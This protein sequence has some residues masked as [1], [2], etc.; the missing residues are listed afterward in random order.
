MSSS[1]RSILSKG[2]KKLL[3]DELFAPALSA[4]ALP[5]ILI[6]GAPDDPPDVPEA[7]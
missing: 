7:A 3:A 5:W 2:K 4:T 6:T 1:A